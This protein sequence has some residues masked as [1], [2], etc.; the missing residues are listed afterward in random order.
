MKQV[1]D[2]PT[3]ITDKTETI[4][5]IDVI[6]TPESNDILKSGVMHNS[7]SDHALVYCIIPTAISKPKA[8]YKSARSFRY[9]NLNKY[10]EDLLNADFKEIFKKKYH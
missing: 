3:R 6:L 7:L 5:V 8:V 1:I 10:K 2:E 9:L 4:I